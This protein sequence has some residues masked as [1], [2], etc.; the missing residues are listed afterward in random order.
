MKKVGKLEL[1]QEIIE[2]MT[3]TDGNGENSHQ[4][5]PITTANTQD[6]G[7]TAVCHRRSITDNSVRKSSG[8]SEGWTMA[9]AMTS[10]WHGKKSKEEDCRV[11]EKGYQLEYRPALSLPSDKKSHRQ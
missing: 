2:E 5:G 9:L 3:E 1:L 4:T 11:E 10:L 8:E 6:D 7:L